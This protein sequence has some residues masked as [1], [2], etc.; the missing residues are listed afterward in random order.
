MPFLEAV[1]SFRRPKLEYTFTSMLDIV[2]GHATTMPE[3]WKNIAYS[4]RQSWVV[5]WTMKSKQTL[6]LVI[7]Q[8]DC[9]RVFLIWTC[10][11]FDYILD[12]ELDV[13]VWL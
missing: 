5:H 8:E 2:I 11:K 6:S 12:Q 9:C 3:H 7:I 4:F 1:V 10:S 13:F